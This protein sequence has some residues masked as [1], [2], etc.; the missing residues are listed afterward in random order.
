M[1]SVFIRLSI[2]K[3][4]HCKT[5]QPTAIVHLLTENPSLSFFLELISNIHNCRQP[6]LLNIVRFEKWNTTSSEKHQQ[7]S[8]CCSC[9]RASSNSWRGMHNLFQTITQIRKALPHN[10]STHHVYYYYY[11]KR[12][13]TRKMPPTTVGFILGGCVIPRMIASCRTYNQ[14]SLHLHCNVKVFYF[15]A[16][17]T[18]L[19]LYMR[20]IS[21]PSALKRLNSHYLLIGSR[22][23]GGPFER[24][25]IAFCSL[26]AKQKL[27]SPFP[28][29]IQKMFDWTL[30]HP[31]PIHLSAFDKCLYSKAVWELK[32]ISQR[33]WH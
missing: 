27:R 10:L 4:F 26:A 23:R 11:E 1:T 17:Y 29:R 2:F 3:R 19:A 16:R 12:G 9:K 6:K 24:S 28:W 22:S 33:C 7:K 18:E 25:L 31:S 5:R 15:F 13:K 20:M 30:H 32:Y 14:E 21:K 8:L